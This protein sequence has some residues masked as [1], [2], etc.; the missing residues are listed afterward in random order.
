[1]QAVDILRD[2]G[3]ELPL[4]LPLRELFMRGIGVGGKAEH[5]VP[6]KVKKFLRMAVEKGARK[7]GL[8]R[9]FIFLAVQPVLRAEVG[10]TALRAY[11]GPAEKDAPL[12]VR[13]G[14]AQRLDPFLQ[15][16]IHTVHLCFLIRFWEDVSAEEGTI[17]SATASP[18]SPSV[19]IRRMTKK[20]IK[21]AAQYERFMACR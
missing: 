13:D 8:G 10:D 5:L 12:H 14:S 21:K 17:A 7:Y 15:L 2:D 11:P 9:I 3:G 18:A 6:I 20:T 4:F 1:M 19:T 16:F